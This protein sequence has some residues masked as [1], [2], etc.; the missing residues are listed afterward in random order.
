MVRA[1]E[2]E[3]HGDKDIQR[4]LKRLEKKGSNK[5]IRAG[6]GRMLTVVA[7]F[8]RNEVPP[9]YRSV[10]RTVGKKHKI[11]D[12]EVVVA[13]VGF[14]VGKRSKPSAS[15]SRGQGIS[16]YNIHWFV[17]GTKER[18]GPRGAMPEAP[19][20]IQNAVAAGGRQAIEEGK[21]KML[22]VILQEAGKRS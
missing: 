5:A 4:R 3:I 15:K 10:K 22:M 16:K 11:K 8:I 17:L 9:R 1:V 19:D 20:W 2:F 13:K 18:S 7:K 12:G 21:E 6:I 14:G